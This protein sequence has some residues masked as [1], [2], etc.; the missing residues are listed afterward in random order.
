[1]FDHLKFSPSKVTWTEATS[2]KQLKDISPGTDS[3]NVSP[4]W[5][6]L[7]HNKQNIIYIIPDLISWPNLGSG[8]GTVGRGPGFIDGI[9]CNLRRKCEIKEKE[10]GNGSSKN[11]H[12][13][14][15]VLSSPTILWP[16][17]Q[18]PS[19]PSVLFSIYIVKIETVGMRKWRK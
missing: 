8:C 13:S 7:N 15:V 17:V 9:L 3:S 5:R 11:G 10:A 19:T 12:H 6:L 4:M 14:S 1:M 18:I 2:N 16:R